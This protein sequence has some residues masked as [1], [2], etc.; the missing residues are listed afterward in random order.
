[1]LCKEENELKGRKFE[2]T[3]SWADGIGKSYDYWT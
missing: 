1:M 2:S 3:F